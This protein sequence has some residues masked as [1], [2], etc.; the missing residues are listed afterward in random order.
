MK[1][2]SSS[3]SWWP[4]SRVV[5]AIVNVTQLCSFAA[6]TPLTATDGHNKS[7]GK[8]GA[9]RE[10]VVNFNTSFSVQ[11]QVIVALVSTRFFWKSARVRLFRTRHHKRHFNQEL[12][13]LIGSCLL[14][15]FL[16]PAPGATKGNYRKTS[17]S[18]QR[19]VH[20]H[21]HT[22]RISLSKTDSHSPAPRPQTSDGLS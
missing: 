2:D 14:P 1:G 10:T 12:Q 22:L 11:L 21:T 15:S 9:E 7:R 20:T 18:P 3:V 4:I 19:L 8:L 17:C 13:P 16:L 6:N 5:W